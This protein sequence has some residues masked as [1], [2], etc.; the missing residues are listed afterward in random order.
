MKKPSP[1]TLRKL[2]RS[3]IGTGVFWLVFI[4]ALYVW[5]PYDR[6]K[7]GA[8]DVASQPGYDVDIASAGA[9]RGQRGGGARGG[10]GRELLENPGQDAADDG[11]ADALHDREG[12]RH[13][14][15]LE[16]D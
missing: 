15:D 16:R 5:F 6:A 2:R 12:D 14:L 10:R 4:V 11:Q 9:A 13:D 1:E 7:E 3:A 8:I